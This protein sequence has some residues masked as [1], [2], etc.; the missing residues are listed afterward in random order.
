MRA[1]ES[2]GTMPFCIK[3]GIVLSR[4]TILALSGFFKGAAFCPRVTLGASKPLAS[5]RLAKHNPTLRIHAPSQF[6]GPSAQLVLSRT[7]IVWPSLYTHVSQV[8]F[9]GPRRGLRS[10][11]GAA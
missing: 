2:P 9:L 1:I 4:R 7:P 3:S 6:D 11:A 5:R 8:V 10:L